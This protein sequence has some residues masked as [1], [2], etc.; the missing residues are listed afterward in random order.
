MVIAAAGNCNEPLGGGVNSL[1]FKIDKKW[2]RGGYPMYVTA[3][4]E[5]TTKQQQATRK[6]FQGQ[7]SRKLSLKQLALLS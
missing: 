4:A 5:Q 1:V 3:A 6:C 7:S 2:R